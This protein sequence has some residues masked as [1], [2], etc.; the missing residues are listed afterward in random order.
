MN[1]MRMLLSKYY[2]QRSLG[3]PPGVATPAVL[4]A[5]SVATPG[6]MDPLLFPCSIIA[7][8]LTAL[9]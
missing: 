5:S 7:E 2:S 1:V 4:R 9:Q 6:P 3:P 8:Y